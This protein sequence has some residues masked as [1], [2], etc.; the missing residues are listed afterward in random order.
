LRSFF[1]CRKSSSDD[2]VVATAKSLIKTWKKFVP[3]SGGD[4][5]AKVA[6]PKA[7][8]TS[9]CRSYDFIIYNRNSGANPTTFEFIATTPA[10]STYA[11][12]FFTSKNIF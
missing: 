6:D 11:R 10:C 4:V 7:V 2:D 5:K 3:E 12:A 1:E 8:K 9:R